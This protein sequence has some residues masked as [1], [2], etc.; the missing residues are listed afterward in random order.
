MISFFFSCASW[1]ICSIVI[2]FASFRL[3]SFFFFIIFFSVLSTISPEPLK[4][5][6]QVSSISQSQSLEMDV[7]ECHFLT[8]VCCF[9]FA[10]RR[11]RT[12]K[13]QKINRY[14]F[15]RCKSN[16]TSERQ[17]H[18]KQFDLKFSAILC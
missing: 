9:F 2:F 11:H 3:R 8:L 13:S 4:R 15:C 1:C 14:K 5:I 17:R 7:R 12:N 10:F 16:R 18:S 6:S